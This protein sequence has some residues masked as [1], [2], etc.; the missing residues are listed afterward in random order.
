MIV[1]DVESICDEVR[2]CKQ[3]W[4]DNDGG[5]WCNNACGLIKESEAPMNELYSF[6]LPVTNDELTQ[7]GWM[8]LMVAI[9]R[10]V[11]QQEA[12]RLLRSATSRRK[13]SDEDFAE[14]EHYLSS[15]ATWTQISKIF[16]VKTSNVFKLYQIWKTKQECS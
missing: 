8:A 3:C 13:W 15:G 14:I 6:P 10:G 7:E 11:P 5:L 12:F 16:G 2:K 4:A 1:Y 9:L